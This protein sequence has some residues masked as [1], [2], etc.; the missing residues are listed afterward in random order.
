MILS[1]TNNTPFVPVYRKLVDEYKDAII[2]RQFHPGDKIDSINEIQRKHQVSRET[3]KLVLKLLAKEGLIVQ[4]VGKG[5]YVANLSPM[6][7]LW[8]VILP[9]F[10]V[11]YQDLLYNLSRQA[12]SAG[13]QLHS[14]LD[15]DNWEEEIRLVGQLIN[16]RYEAVIIIPTLDE[17]RTAPFYHGLSPRETHVV[18]IDHTM[19]GSAFSYVIGSYDLGVE[20]GI[21]YLRGKKPKGN[22]VFVRNEV[23]LGRNLVQE[24]MEETFKNTLAD[25]GD[26]QPLIIDKVENVDADLVRNNKISGIF[27]CDDSDA[28][29]VIGK[30]KTQGVIVGADFSLVSYGNTELARYFTPAITSI[31]PHNS[32]M[33][34]KIA[35]ILK[36][37]IEEK[38]TDFSQY[39]VSPELVVR[40]T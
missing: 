38:A 14:F 35:E 37:K 21:R 40:E 16:E 34:V 32:E 23:T 30:L 1:L 4:K 12:W 5:S 36:Q 39:V 31:D 29:R 27:C 10:S 20:R 26:N 3:A 17:S 9:F 33:A 2:T 25:A 8:G 15:H 11:Q 28:I 22:I 24:L 7:K 18:L 19:A 13:R 6:K